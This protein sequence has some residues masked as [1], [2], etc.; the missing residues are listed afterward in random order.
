MNPV[1]LYSDLLSGKPRALALG[2]PG[3]DFRL[4]PIACLGH[5]PNAQIR[6]HVQSS[7]V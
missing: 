2:F 5:A 1:S 6:P 4:L 7:R 3:S